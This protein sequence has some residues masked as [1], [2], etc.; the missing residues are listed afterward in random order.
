M[1]LLPHR[2]A[3]RIANII[4]SSQLPEGQV[5]GLEAVQ[6]FQLELISVSATLPIKSG[7]AMMLICPDPCPD[8]TI[9][10][11][12]LGGEYFVSSLSRQVVTDYLPFELSVEH[13]HKTSKVV[14]NSRGSVQCRGGSVAEGSEFE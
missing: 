9:G 2:D 12:V 3:M 10:D 13:P 11:V 5:I 14:S 8:E 7:N 4:Y 6:H 1:L